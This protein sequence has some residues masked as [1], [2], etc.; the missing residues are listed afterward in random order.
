MD[1]IA[2]HPTTIC[3]SC[4]CSVIANRTMSSACEGP[5]SWNEYHNY[6]NHQHNH[7]DHSVCG[8]HHKYLNLSDVATSL[9]A[10]NVEEVVEDTLHHSGPGFHNFFWSFSN[11]LIFCHAFF[12]CSIITL[13]SWP[14]LLN[15]DS[16][17]KVW[18]KYSRIGYLPRNTGS[19]DNVSKQL[20]GE[21][22]KRPREK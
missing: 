4:M 20:W 5:R 17:N 2:V 8:Q 11:E 3:F 7:D 22:A 18:E 15:K 14:I 21:R 1:E 19:L 6:H 13:T 9:Q 12:Q 10:E 16:S